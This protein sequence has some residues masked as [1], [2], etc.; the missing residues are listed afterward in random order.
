MPLIRDMT[1]LLVAVAIASAVVAVAATSG[2]AQVLALTCLV[3]VAVLYTASEITHP[4]TW[5]GPIFWLYSA[6][7]PMLAVAGLYSYD[8]NLQTAVTLHALAFASFCMPLLWCKR[9]LKIDHWNVG[10]LRLRRDIAFSI[11]AVL[12][13][14]IVLII[15][16]VGSLGAASKRELVD[17]GS[18]IVSALNSVL[19]LA[20]FAYCV[21]AVCAVARGDSIWPIAAVALLCF[22]IVIVM[23]G[24]R[25]Y[26]LRAL[27]ITVLIVWDFRRRPKFP[28]IV[29]IGL[30]VI[31]A[32]PWLQSL[33]AA[34]LGGSAGGY[35]FELV[36]LFSQE[37]R[38][39]AQNTYVVLARDV[40]A[41]ATPVQVLSR[42]LIRALSPNILGFSA[43]STTSW[44][45][46]TIYFDLTS[47]R[48]FT[49]VGYG[50]LLGGAA[51]VC[52]LYAVM[53]MIYRYVYMR[54]SRSYM[55]LATYV[56]MVPLWMY[57]QRADIG[58]WLAQM[59]RS[60]L[61]LLIVFSFLVI[62]VRVLCS[63]TTRRCVPLWAKVRA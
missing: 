46:A 28:A 37:F 43:Q 25:D 20:S 55:W 2:L 6:A 56:L 59:S 32:L 1:A 4:I 34:G 42:D 31:V 52:A 5:F 41:Y 61:L 13:P 35:Q 57:V 48:G 15:F 9:A 39:A 62:A 7:Y 38:V 17:M 50:Y 11:L 63:S 33:K 51:G 49:L 40:D 21:Y 53:G 23:V 12:F 27:V 54:R 44:F 30:G 24:E 29:A 19:I 8:S 26:L 3:A 22:G 14:V 58:T 60:I 16:N 47:G 10:A 45:N 36:S 18:G